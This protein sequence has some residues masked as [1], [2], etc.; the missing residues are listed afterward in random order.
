MRR[1]VAA[2]FAIEVLA[3]C[4]VALAASDGS[5]MEAERVRVEM[6]QSGCTVDP[7]TG[8]V[9]GRTVFVASN[10]SRRARRFAIA[11]SRTSF[12][13]P[14]RTATLLAQLHAGR[15][16]YTCSA[17]GS[18]RSVHKG[19]ITVVRPPAIARIGIRG[20]RFTIV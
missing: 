5:S 17:S 15:V 18:P 20:G 8:L 4:V 14:G 3:T 16:G 11:G 7:N 2:G 13:K 6:R 10:R 1:V 12:L 9:P 19:A